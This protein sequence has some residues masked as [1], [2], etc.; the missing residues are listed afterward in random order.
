MNPIEITAP[1]RIKQLLR[2]FVQSFRA[3]LGENLSGVY[4]HGSLAMGCFN[5]LSSDVDILV[6]VNQP[7]PDPVKYEI[8]HILLQL[9]DKFPG[10]GIEMSV[11]TAAS[12]RNFQHPAPY[13]LHFSDGNKADYAEGRVHFSNEMFDPDLAAH[14][15]IT[16]AR[17]ICLFGGQIDGLFP[18]IPVKYYLDSIVQDSDWS[19]ANIMRGPDSGEGWVPAYGVLNFCRVLA[20]TE[21]SLI[22]S[23]LE[24]GRWALDHLP[25]EYASVIQ[26]ALQ[27]YTTNGQKYGVDLKLLKQ[28]ASYAKLTIDRSAAN[29]VGRDSNP[30]HRR[31]AKVVQG[32]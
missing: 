4:L 7:L 26:A 14:V 30:A 16:K 12:L 2:A 17:G 3:T 27:E 28:F 11:L 29:L 5:P 31:Q 8:G 18:D 25:K 19:Y 6:V 22:T 13:E 23:K 10:N 32:E 9:S 21:H 15:V 20:F 1:D 24:G